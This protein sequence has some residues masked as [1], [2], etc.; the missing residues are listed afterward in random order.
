[1]V[2][3][4]PHRAVR[5]VSGDQ[6]GGTGVA[7]GVP[8]THGDAAG[9]S[10]WWRSRVEMMGFLVKMMGFLDLY[11]AFTGELYGI[12]DKNHAVNCGIYDG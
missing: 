9:G 7:P 3:P 8:V 4:P 5:L 6:S 12:Y 10:P 11:G 2:P 1:M